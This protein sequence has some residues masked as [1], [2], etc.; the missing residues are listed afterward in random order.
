[1]ALGMA[2]FHEVLHLGYTWE[3]QKIYIYLLHPKSCACSIAT[4]HYKIKIH[5]ILV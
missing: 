1:M 3:Y 5:I 2:T 4:A